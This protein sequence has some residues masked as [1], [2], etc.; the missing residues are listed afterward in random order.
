MNLPN[1]LLSDFVAYTK[2]ARYRPELGRREV[3][4]ETVA[5]VEAM[6]LGQFPELEYEIR[7][8][9]RWVYQRKVLPS[10]RAMQFAGKPILLAPNRQYNCSYMPA[11]RPTFFS[12][13]MYLLLGGTGVGYSVQ[14]HHVERLP[15][16]RPAARWQQFEIADSIEGWSDAVRRLVD[17]YFGLGPLAR[18]DYSRIRPKGALLVT[19]GGKAPGPEPLRQC[20]R[21]LDERLGAKEAGERLTPLEVHDLACCIADAVLAGGIRRAAMIALF[22]RTDEAMLNC[23]SG[24]WWE[25]HPYRARANNSVVLPRWEVSEAEFRSLVARTEASGFGEPGF[26]WTNDQSLDWGTNPCGEI[27]LRPYQ[28]CNLTTFN[29]SDIHDQSEL[30]HRAHAAA[31]IGTLQAAY[32]RFTYLSPDWRTTTE[33]EA[34]CGVSMTGVADGRTLNLDIAAAARVVNQVNATL[35]AALGIQPAAR[36]TCIKPEGTSSLVLGTASGVHARHAPYYLRRIR[37]GRSEAIAQ[38]LLRHHPELLEPCAEKPQAQLIFTCP[39]AAPPHSALREESPFELLGRIERLYTDWVLPGHQTGV[40]THNVSATVT[41]QPDHWRGVTD[42]LWANRAAYQG[43]S[44]LPFDTGGYRQ[45]P[46]EAC[47][48]ADYHDRSQHLRALDLS[49]V[50]EAAADIAPATRELACAGAACEIV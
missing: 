37:L 28:F 31:T 26:F 15:E 3:F 2:Y 40:N 19:S 32:T 14:R 27:S 33:A 41:P 21:H 11:E 42:W 46:F 4:A 47:T 39:Q 17:G 20:L 5:R 6:H 49:H 18:F 12:E 1:Q 25:A 16:L 29:A 22:D 7:G 8:A 23:K 36:T 48:E 24:A 9:F 45:A 10:M 34:L 13:L 50:R 38:Y 44:L 35:A 30:E 43:I